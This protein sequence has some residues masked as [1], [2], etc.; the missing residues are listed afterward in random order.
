MIVNFT[1]MPNSKTPYYN[2]NN[3]TTHRQHFKK[4]YKLV[5]NHCIVKQNLRLDQSTILGC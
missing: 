2:I 5:R 1:I 4:P 3:K